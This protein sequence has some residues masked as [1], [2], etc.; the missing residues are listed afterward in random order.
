[1]MKTYLLKNVMTRCLLVLFIVAGLSEQV[2]ANGGA[3]VARITGKVTSGVDGAGM[4]G[5]NVLIKG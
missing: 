1:M 3:V 5:V 4:P 2:L